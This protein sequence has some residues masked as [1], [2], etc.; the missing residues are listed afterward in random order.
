MIVTNFSGFSW[1][2]D[3]SN[4]PSCLG[5]GWL[6]KSHVRNVRRFANSARTKR[7][8]PKWAVLETPL[9]RRR[10]KPQRG[11][12][13]AGCLPRNFEQRGESF[14]DTLLTAC[15]NRIRTRE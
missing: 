4:A 10:D 3:I 6:S 12:P 2:I 8:A 13:N 14:G 11:E 5:I 9:P 7:S 1:D 15:R